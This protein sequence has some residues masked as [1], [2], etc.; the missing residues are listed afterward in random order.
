MV[1]SK[2]GLVL[3]VVM[4]VLIFSWIR[5]VTIEGWLGCS[6]VT[7]LF[8]G[9]FGISSCVSFVIKVFTT[10]RCVLEVIGENIL[11]MC[12]GSRG[13]IFDVV[14]IEAFFVSAGTLK[15]SVAA[16]DPLACAM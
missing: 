7:L 2:E 15:I 11:L 16:F 3:I 9:V 5:V 4:V 12:H 1:I 6:V 13:N 14:R 8:C 10:E